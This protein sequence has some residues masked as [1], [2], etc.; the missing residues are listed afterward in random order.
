MRENS[1]IR[2]RWFT[3]PDL[4]VWGFPGYAIIP[5][6][7]SLPLL[8]DYLLKIVRMNSTRKL[9]PLLGMSI[10]L[11][12]TSCPSDDSVSDVMTTGYNIRFVV[13]TNPEDDL[14]L[15]DSSTPIKIMKGESVY[16]NNTSEELL[17]NAPVTSTGFG[18]ISWFF[19]GGTP[20]A[21]DNGR[22]P[23]E[24]TYDTP[25]KYDVEIT[26]KDTD[27]VFVFTA[28]VCV[29]APPEPECPIM[30]ETFDDGSMAEFTYDSL[31]RLARIDKSLNGVLQEYTTYTYNIADDLPFRESFFTADDQLLGTK[32]F[33]Y[34]AEGQIIRELRENADGSLVTDITFTWSS[35]EG[36]FPTATMLAP[37]GIGGTFVTDITYSYFAD[38]LNLQQEEFSVNG[39]VVGLTEYTFDGSPKVYSGLFIQ[40]FAERFSQNNLTSKVTRDASG[41]ILTQTTREYDYGDNCNGKAVGV[42]ETTDGN[43]R[44]GSYTYFETEF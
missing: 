1:S 13:L 37:D 15:S 22:S 20:A 19:P 7:I 17:I 8:E 44:E 14:F 4:R 24:V 33:E 2:Q 5:I 27:E 6:F 12:M 26:N 23:F 42:T 34:N 31:G 36:T 38:K 35:E 16:F 9:M 11:L 18:N 41:T 3:S 40:E 29:E 32:T 25:G 43:T 10:V 30:S 21:S 28:Y 39:T